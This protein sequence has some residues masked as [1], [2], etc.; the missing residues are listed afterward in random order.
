[1]LL[2]LGLLYE[3]SLLNVYFV[4]SL[5]ANILHHVEQ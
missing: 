1:M 4:R 5:L 3:S 2:H